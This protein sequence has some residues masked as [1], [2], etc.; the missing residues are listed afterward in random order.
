MRGL[1]CM[2]HSELTRLEILQR[3]E[4]RRLNQSQAAT[5]LGM[6]PRQ[7]RRLVRSYRTQGAEGLVSKKRGKIGNHR[8]PE[9]FREHILAIIREL[10]A[11]FGPTLAREKLLERHGLLVPCET[12]RGWMRDA[13]IWLPRAARRKMIQQ[14]RARRQYFGELIQIDGSE[15]HWFEDRGAYCTVLTYVDDATSRLQ[16]L[17][18]VEGESTF[19]YICKPRGC[20]S[21]GTANLWRSTATSTQ[22]FGSTNAPLS[23]ATA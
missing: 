13:G 21:S 10:Y 1:I 7:M 22:S 4:D 19:D 16:L 8:R 18:F 15:H 23:A 3:V 12:L 6:T 17:R 5:M 11:D 14:P 9:A 2:S 20:T